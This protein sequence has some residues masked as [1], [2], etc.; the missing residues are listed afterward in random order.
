MKVGSVTSQ[1]GLHYQMPPSSKEWMKKIRY[2]ALVHSFNGDHRVYSK[3]ARRG[4]GRKTVKPT[5]V[6]GE[7]GKPFFTS[8]ETVITRNSL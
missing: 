7:T 5:K 6:S 4:E 3:G 1:I 8:F 2:L